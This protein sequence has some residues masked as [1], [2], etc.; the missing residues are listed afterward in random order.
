[1]WD[2]LKRAREHKKE[3][4]ANSQRNRFKRRVDYYSFSFVLF[5]SSKILDLWFIQIVNLKRNKINF[6]PPKIRIPSALQITHLNVSHFEI[7]NAI[8]EMPSTSLPP[9][10]FFFTWNAFKIGL[11]LATHCVING[12][13]FFPLL[14][15]LYTPFN[16]TLWFIANQGNL[17]S[18]SPANDVYQTHTHRFPISQRWTFIRCN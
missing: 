7:W 12:K 14:L 2:E 9:T 4:K 10:S 3:S 16:Y 13:Y 6:V 17:K 8:N 1:M 11:I 5:F 18:V 15:H